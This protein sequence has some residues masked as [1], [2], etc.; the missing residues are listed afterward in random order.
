MTLTTQYMAQLSLTT[1]TLSD[2][3]CFTV[4]RH[5]RFTG[6]AEALNIGFHGGN[7]INGKRKFDAEAPTSPR[8]CTSALKAMSCEKFGSPDHKVGWLIV[9]FN[10]NMHVSRPNSSVPV[11]YTHLTLPTNREV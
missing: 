5:E 1:M 7:Y 6:V 10:Y 3:T 11:S 9:V 4:D 8:K 2:P